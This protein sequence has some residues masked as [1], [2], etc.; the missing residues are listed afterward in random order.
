MQKW[1]L[2]NQKFIFCVDENNIMKMLAWKCGKIL[3]QVF[4]ASC[5][6]E[7]ASVLS[8]FLILLIASRLIVMKLEILSENSF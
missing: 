8:Y 5:V 7:S 2:Q 4:L 6:K 3:L 1:K